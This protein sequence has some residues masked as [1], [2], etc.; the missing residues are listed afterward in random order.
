MGDQCEGADI[1]TICTRVALGLGASESCLRP[2]YTETVLGPES[3]GIELDPGSDDT[4]G[5]GT[6]S[7]RQT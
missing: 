6:S 7:T 2:G 3:I 5:Q 4:W 1:E